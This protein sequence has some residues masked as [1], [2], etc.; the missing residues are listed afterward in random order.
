M[1]LA[2]TYFQDLFS[3]CNLVRLEEAVSEVQSE[4]SPKMNEFLNLPYT[5]LEVKEAIFQMGATKSS[6]PDGMPAYF[7]SEILE[8]G[9]K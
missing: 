4:V 6:D 2:Q 8:P 1:G 7:F 9:R 3:T 5:A